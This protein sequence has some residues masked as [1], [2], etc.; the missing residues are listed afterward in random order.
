[1]WNLAHLVLNI[2][3]PAQA[4]S[5]FPEILTAHIS[6]LNEAFYKCFPWF[7]THEQ[8]DSWIW[9][10]SSSCLLVHLL[11]HSRSRLRGLKCWR[12]TVIVITRLLLF[13]QLNYLRKTFLAKRLKIFAQAT[14]LKIGHSL[15]IRNNMSIIIAIW[16]G[17]ITH[18][19]QVL[20][21]I[22]IPTPLP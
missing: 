5:W 20:W 9:N 17:R 21:T 13:Q 16:A 2:L 3:S 7:S 11:T 14:V 10:P 8:T 22:Y 19:W 15:N 6:P 4:L 18:T 12:H 1:M